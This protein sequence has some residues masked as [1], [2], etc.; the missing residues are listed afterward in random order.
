MIYAKVGM[1]GHNTLEW[2]KNLNKVRNSIGLT[3][4]LQPDG[5]FGP[6]TLSA[7]IKVQRYLGVKPDGIVGDLTLAAWRKR[8]PHIS[9]GMLAPTHQDSTAFDIAALKRAKLQRKEAAIKASYVPEQVALEE[10]KK[11]GFAPLL[12]I[13][14]IA[15]K[16]MKVF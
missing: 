12:I 7:T 10:P 4:P 6:K 5:I 13:S 9:T 14:A 3:I 8:W 16:L 2:Q 11:A 1:R 15:A